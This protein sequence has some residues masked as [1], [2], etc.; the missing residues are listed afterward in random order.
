MNS[1]PGRSG[2]FVVFLALALVLTACSNT[3]DGEAADTLATTTTL[4]CV[5]AGT[6]SETPGGSQATPQPTEADGTYQGFP[7][8]FTDDGYP[9]LGD[10]DAPVSLVEF[11]D[12]LC[13]YCGRHFSET[14]PRL[15]EQYGLDG[16]VNFVFRDFPL[17]GLH[18]AAPSG[19]AAA[20]CV[21]EQSA[22][23]FWAMHDELFANQGA[24]ASLTDNSDYLGG[25]AEEIGADPDA[26]QICIDS[27]R[28]AAVV[29]QRI[30]QGRG[31][32][33]SATPS[34]HIV[35]NRTDE[36]F[37]VIGAQPVA[38]FVAALDAVIAGEDPVVAGEPDAPDLPRW[39]SAE[40][41]APDPDRPGYNL[42]GDAYRGDPEAE[43]VVIEISDFQ[44]PFCR[45]HMRETQPAIDEAY[46]ETGK[47][48]WV[49]KHLPLQ[50]HPQ[51]QAAAAAAE[52]AGE[53]GAFW[54]MHDLL[55]ERVEGWSVEPPDEA[56]TGLAL[57]LGLD[58]E[59][60]ALCWGGPYD[61][62]GIF[63]STPT[64]VVLFDGRA[65]V[66]EGAQPFEDFVAAFE[67]MLNE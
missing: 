45:R 5:A 12:Y 23:L 44:C 66:I 4:D 21:A 30:A 17:A 19:H 11:S 37:E 58:R 15:L 60:F 41:L 7:V 53:Q 48:M 56:L 49:F 61:L 29:E 25:L 34:F 27:G 39:A 13:P 62:S 26:Y 32:G 6:C 40:G 28:T 16:R 8:G 59:A 65:S 55:F 33:F 63:G 22:A 38:T 14:T 64:V 54:E 9:Y 50:S 20:L 47:V 24:W 31:L 46:V 35:D 36:I 1:Q 3:T 18:P 57:E 10:A 51:A 52:C 42:A 67:G 2:R 43:L